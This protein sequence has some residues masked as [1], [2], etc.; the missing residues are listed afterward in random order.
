MSMFV[1][2]LPYDQDYEVTS[3][4]FMGPYNIAIDQ[5]NMAKQIR[6]KHGENIHWQL[7]CTADIDWSDIIP[8]VKNVFTSSLVGRT[9]DQGV[10]LAAEKIIE[11]VIYKETSKEVRN[12]SENDNRFDPNLN[13]RSNN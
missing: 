6:E 1:I 7:E 9:L 11:T 2:V 10:L 4:D 12:R 3:A 5:E 8:H 13:W